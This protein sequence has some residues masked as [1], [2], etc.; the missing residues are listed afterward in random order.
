MVPPI[1]MTIEIK[2]IH[3]ILIYVGGHVIVRIPLPTYMNDRCPSGC[4][5]LDHVVYPAA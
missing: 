2:S 5:M 1:L 4:V 3:A